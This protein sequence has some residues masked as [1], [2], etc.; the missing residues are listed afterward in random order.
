[1]P[2]RRRSDCDLGDL[3][4]LSRCELGHLWRQQFG[5]E[6]PSSFGGDLLALAI[7]H[8]ARSYSRLSFRCGKGVRLI[9][10]S[11]SSLY[12]DAADVDP[13]MTLAL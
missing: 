8:S 7:A 4:R 13:Q 11:L 6:P 2:A 9:G 3:D 1:M 10:V 12:A 5:G